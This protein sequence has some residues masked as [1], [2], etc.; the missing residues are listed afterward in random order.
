M[1][2]TGKVDIGVGGGVGI[3]Q[4]GCSGRPRRPD[5][6]YTTDPVDQA[7]AVTNTCASIPD[8][9]LTFDGRG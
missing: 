2:D 6:Q 8:K 4:E 7:Y 3:Q 9:I 5:K 1:F